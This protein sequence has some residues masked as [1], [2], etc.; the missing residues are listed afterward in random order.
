MEVGNHVADVC[1]SPDTVDILYTACST[2][3]TT[4]AFWSQ[5]DE[6]VLVT[7]MHASIDLLLVSYYQTLFLR[8][9]ELEEP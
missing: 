8:E 3:A 6:S 7:Y 9:R 2:F 5:I 4:E 1:T